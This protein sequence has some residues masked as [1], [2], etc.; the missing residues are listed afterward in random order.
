LFKKSTILGFA[1]GIS[2][3][4][5]AP[6]LR[7]FFFGATLT[8]ALT[9]TGV[10]TAYHAVVD[11]WMGKFIDLQ[12]FAGLQVPLTA[13][14]ILHGRAEPFQRDPV[15]GLEHSIAGWKGIVE[16][17]V[18]REAAHGKTVDLPDRTGVALAL[19]VNALDG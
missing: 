1:C 10:C 8:A 6:Q 7:N 18:A 2:Y 16:G 13:K 19:L 5:F 4:I 12:P 3:S 17:R 15:A 14:P 9:Y 11:S